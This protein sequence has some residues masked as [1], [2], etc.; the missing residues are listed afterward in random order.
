M[1]HWEAN[2]A[3]DEWYTPKY[4]FDALG[5]RFDL[6]VAAPLSNR[7]HVP[8][9]LDLCSGSLEAFWHGFV[10][11]NPPFG[12]RNGLTPWLEKFVQH[13][14]GIAL[15]PDRTSAPWFQYIASHADCILFLS[16]K[17]KFERPDGTLGKSPSTGTALIAIGERGAVA[18]TNGAS[19]GLGF[20]ASPLSS[21]IPDIQIKGA[22]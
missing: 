3:S 16:P 10:W 20:L 8:A 17:V 22:A 19:N 5:C 18:L 21:R 9:A 14:N 13:G 4:I 7:T 12:G 6:D 15:V 1:S 11:M 2:G